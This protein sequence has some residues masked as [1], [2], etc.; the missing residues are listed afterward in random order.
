MFGSFDK[1]NK[2]GLPYLGSPVVKSEG[3]VRWLSPG[4]DP[5]GRPNACGV[6]NPN[7]DENQ[8][9]DHN[10]RQGCLDQHGL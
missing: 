2:T 9:D 4:F 7:K 3:S 6:L 5:D 8:E 1:E 10:N